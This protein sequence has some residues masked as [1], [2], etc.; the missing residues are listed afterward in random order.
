ML[1]EKG[2]YVEA[3]MLIRKPVDLVFNAFIDPEI[4]TNFWFTHS[5]G[6]LHLHKEVEWIWEMYQV[7]TPVLVTELIFNEKIS[8]DWGKPATKVDFLFKKI[9]DDATYVTINH[10][11]F[12]EK[13]TELVE[14][15]KDSTGGFNTVLDGL[16]AYL[17]YGINLHLIRDKFLH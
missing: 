3:Q 15:I 10:Y 13:G 2:I 1:L 7:A 12:T 6:K 4:T 5:S 16:K 17:E 8:I 14:K 11:G 9:S